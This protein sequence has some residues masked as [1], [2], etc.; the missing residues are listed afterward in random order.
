MR[1]IFSALL[2][3]ILGLGGSLRADE[4][5]RQVQEELRKRNLYF[6]DIDGRS[7]PD[8]ENALRRY[9][10]RKRFP[11]SGLIDGTTAASLKVKLAPSAPPLPDTPVLKTDFAPQMAESQRAA[12]EAEAEGVADPDLVPTPPPPPAEAPSS[13]QDINPQRVTELVENYLRDSETDDVRAQ[14][15]PYFAYPVDYF[16][17]GAKGEDFIVRDVSNYVQRWPERRYHLR[18]PVIFAAS[19]NEDETN[20]QFEIAFE[21]ENKK[22]RALARGRTLNYWTIRPEDGQLKITSIKEERLRE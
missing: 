18:G 14:T 21:V 4:T 19:E 17:H 2:F 12:L 13:S 3:V 15:D 10:S 11:V 1:R 22:R 20:I 7:S 8:L 9:Q 5:V 16:V 6:G